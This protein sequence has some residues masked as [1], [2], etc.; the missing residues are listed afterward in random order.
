MISVKS[1]TDVITNSSNE[2]YAIVRGDH[3]TLEDIKEEISNYFGSRD[4]YVDPY[5]STDEETGEEQ[6]EICWDVGY[7]SD[8]NKDIAC[9]I[10][11][12]ILQHTSH[13][14]IKRID[15]ENYY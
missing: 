9:I 3:G 5:F 14:N 1:I 2:S 4:E 13:Y 7:D 11:G 15:Y 6:L 10:K 8:E 12:L